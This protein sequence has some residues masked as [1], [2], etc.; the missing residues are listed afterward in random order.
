MS[1]K[2]RLVLSWFLLEPTAS[3]STA[4]Q[5]G[6][7]VLTKVKTLLAKGKKFRTQDLLQ[8]AKRWEPI[9]TREEE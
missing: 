9:R 4:P 6:A 1:S 3:F 8:P 2:T 7:R 5:I